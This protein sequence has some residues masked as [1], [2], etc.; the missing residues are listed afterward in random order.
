MFRRYHL[1][2]PI[3][4]AGQF[5]NLNTDRFRRGV[6]REGSIFPTFYRYEG[7]RDRLVRP[8]RRIFP[9]TS[10]SSNFF[11]VL[12]NNNG[13]PSVGEM[14]F[15]KACQLT[16]FLLRNPRRRRL[17]LVKG[18]TCLI[19]GRYPSIGNARRSSLITFHANGNSLLVARG[20][21]NNGLVKGNPT[22]SDRVQLILPVTPNVCLNYGIL[23]PNTKDPARRGKSINANGRL[24]RAMRLV[25]FKT[26]ASMRLL[27]I[28]IFVR[29]LHCRDRRVI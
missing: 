16:T 4:T 25:N 6:D 3:G 10:F 27:F 23:L 2:R 29:C 22:I 1:Y 7:P 8:I 13:R 21:K 28:V 12:V 19:R 5:V 20:L 9:R 11:R 18:I 15:H 17:Y 26:F 14:F 24:C